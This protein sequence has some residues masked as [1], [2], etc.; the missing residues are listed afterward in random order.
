MVEDIVKK[1]GFFKIAEN[2]YS[3]KSDCGEYICNVY[4]MDSLDDEEKIIKIL[5][6]EILNQNKE[7]RERILNLMK[8]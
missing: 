5:I 2:S 8:L 3:K 6:D 7:Y 4:I 1:F